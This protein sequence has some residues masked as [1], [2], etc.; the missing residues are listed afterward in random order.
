MT[1]ITST[2]SVC[3]TMDGRHVLRQE[4]VDDI[5]FLEWEDDMNQIDW[6]GLEFE[7]SYG[8]YVAL[9]K[10]CLMASDSIVT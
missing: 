4:G 10:V 3:K 2:E 7:N 6:Y 9:E 8:L 1:Y 5:P